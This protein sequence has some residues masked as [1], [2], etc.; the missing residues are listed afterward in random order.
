[1]ERKYGLNKG[2]ASIK[3]AFRKIGA[4]DICQNSVSYS[5]AFWFAF[6]KMRFG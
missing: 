4:D 2:F 1:M 5:D 6:F 3:N